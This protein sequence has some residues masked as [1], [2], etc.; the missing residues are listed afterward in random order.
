MF[1]LAIAWVLKHSAVT[2]AIV[3]ARHTNQIIENVCAV[4]FEIEKEDMLILDE[5]SES[6]INNQS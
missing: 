3:G 4:N 2:S 5:L 6:F 1:Q